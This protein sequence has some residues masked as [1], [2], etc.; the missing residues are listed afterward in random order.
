MAFRNEEG[1]VT[2]PSHDFDYTN[3]KDIAS[4]VEAFYVQA[5][6]EKLTFR[7]S[8]KLREKAVF[9]IGTIL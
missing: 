7:I 2:F 8:M 4:A 5:S 9:K 6:A 3:Y 1:R